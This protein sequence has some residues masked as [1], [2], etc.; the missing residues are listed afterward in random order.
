MVWAWFALAAVPSPQ[1]PTLL[2]TV[3]DPEGKPVKGATVWLTR[4]VKYDVDVEE[5]G[6]VEADAEGRFAFDT[7]IDVVGDRQRFV[8]LWAHA[9]GKRVYN[10]S[11][12]SRPR[13]EQGPIRLT[14]GP[15]ATTPVRVRG[16]DGKPV[17]GATLRTTPFV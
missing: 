9:P 10:I 1:S 2:G 11:P 12:I 7:P 16:V 3:V 17:A 15:P 5:L 8:T 4:T 13:G 6:Q 14:L